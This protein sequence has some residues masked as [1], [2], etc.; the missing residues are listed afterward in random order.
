MNLNAFE[1]VADQV[2]ATQKLFEDP[3][4]YFDL[5]I[6]LPKLNHYTITM[7]SFARGCIW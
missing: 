6:V 5:P 3:A 4:E 2:R 7:H 1:T